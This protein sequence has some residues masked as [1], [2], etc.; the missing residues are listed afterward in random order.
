MTN[1]PTGTWDGDDESFF[2]EP[3]LDGTSYASSWQGQNTVNTAGAI[4]TPPGG[5]RVVTM[6]PGTNFLGA[7]RST[8]GYVAIRWWDGTLQIIGNGV[9]A[10]THTF[11]K[12]VP[13]S[14]AYSSY[15]PK[16]VYYW[17]ATGSTN[18]F[19]PST[20]GAGITYFS[21][22]GQRLT[23]VDVHG[24]PLTDLNLPSN[25]IQSLNVAN[26]TL[27]TNLY[28]TNN[29]I[30]YMDIANCPA[31]TQFSMS[32]SPLAGTL[33]LSHLP[34]LTS[35]SFIAM[36]N[37]QQIKFCKNGPLYSLDT[38][39]LTS[40]K[41]IDLSGLENLGSISLSSSPLLES[42]EVFS[43]SNLVFLS[44]YNSPS[45]SSVRVPGAV[46]GGYQHPSYTWSFSNGGDLRNCN[47]SAA[48]LNQFYTDLGAA[49]GYGVISV[50]GNP[51]VSSD[52][53]SIA[54]AKDYIIYGS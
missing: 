10:T 27:L 37:L 31:L 6:S 42:I 20:S 39:N 2:S 40:L 3:G 29:P 26:Q 52:N 51:G 30:R 17:A 11:T 43:G 19:P 18:A 46:L 44:C 21:A 50:D 5:V 53:P 34:M 45:L 28:V 12:A 48:A 35:V 9:P 32:Y 49:V 4:N 25:Y 16:E 14:G 23:A 38:Y 15:S 33:D 36:P 54:T 47:L 8:T 24:A 22:S 7:V 13:S 41:S 1:V